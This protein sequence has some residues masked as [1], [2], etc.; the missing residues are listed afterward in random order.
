MRNRMLRAVVPALL[1]TVLTVSGCGGGDSEDDHDHGSDD[2]VVIDPVADDPAIAAKAVALNLFQWNPAEQSSVWDL[3]LQ[4]VD[5]NLTGELRD[6]ATSA[7]GSADTPEEWSAWAASGATVRAIVTS[8]VVEGDGNSRTV[9]VTVQ[10]N[11]EYP[12]G[13][14]SE[15]KTRNVTVHLVNDDGQWKADRVSEGEK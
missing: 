6:K 5:D 1:V 12:D 7:Q 2:H 13:S 11:L 3:P 9:T 8:P 10:Q 14:G 15:W 4:I